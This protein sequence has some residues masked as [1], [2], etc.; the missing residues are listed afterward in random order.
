MEKFRPPFQRWRGP[1]GRAPG[2][3]PQ[4]AKSFPCARRRIS[5]KTVKGVR[6]DDSHSE[7]ERTR[8]LPL[9]AVSGKL[10]LQN[11]TV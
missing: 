2:R 8:P 11:V 5:F 4:S 3:A 1:R 10:Y 7:G 9:L 6:N